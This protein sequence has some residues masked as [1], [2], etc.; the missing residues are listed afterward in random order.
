VSGH[1]FSSQHCCFSFANRDDT[2]DGS[3][4]YVLFEKDLKTT[5]TFAQGILQKAQ[6]IIKLT[7]NANSQNS[8]SLKKEKQVAGS[9]PG[10]VAKIR[11]NLHTG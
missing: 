2:F 1:Q 4:Y 11:S 6:N 5:H 3:T 7:E 10:W 8:Y 9:N